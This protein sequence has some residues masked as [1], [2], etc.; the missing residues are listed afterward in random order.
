MECISLDVYYNLVAPLSSS[1]L[2]RL[3]HFFPDVMLVELGAD[4]CMDILAQAELPVKSVS[5][6]FFS[7]C[8]KS[9]QQQIKSR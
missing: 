5:A 2:I 7:K 1:L 3:P 6:E 8:V 9:H 4:E